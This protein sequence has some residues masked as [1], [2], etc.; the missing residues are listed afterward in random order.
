MV[1]YWFSAPSKFRFT[2][3][4]LPAFVFSAAS[5]ITAGVFA[6]EDPDEADEEAEII[7]EVLVT[8]SRIKRRDFTSISPIATFS[9]EDI[10]FSGITNLEDLAN[11]MPQLVA[12]FG[13][14]SNNPGNGAAQ[15][16]L[17]GLGP[18]RTLVMLNGHRAAPHDVFGAVD[19]NS[20]P[21]ALVQRVELVTG[22]ASTVY[23]SDAVSGVVN[24]ILKTDFTGVELSTQFDIYGAGDGEVI[25]AS[26]SFGSDFSDGRGHIMGFVNYQERSAV[27]ADA[28][29]FTAVTLQENLN[30]P[31][32]ELVESGSTA[33]PGG[34][35]W[36]PPTDLPGIGPTNNIIFNSDGSAR[37]FIDPDDLFNFAPDNYLQT[38]FERKMVGAFGNFQLLDDLNAFAEFSYAE[39]QSDQQLAPSP[40]FEFIAFNVDHPSLTPEQQSLAV[41]NWDADG[42]GIAD[43]F[44]SRRLEEIGPRQLFTNS[45]SWRAL[46]GLKGTFGFDW[47]WE[48]AFSYSE[49]TKDEEQVNGVSR[50]RLLQA[51]L[52]DPASGQC[53]D[54][55]NGCVPVS[56]FGDGSITMEAAEFLRSVDIFNNSTVEEQI[57]SFNTTGDVIDLPA[58]ALAMAVGVEWRDL[59][60]TFVSDPALI[61]GNVLG[62]NSESGVD[63]SFDVKEVYAEVLVPIL[64]GKT[65]AHYLGL[66][67]GVRYSD[68][69]LSGGAW[70]W[71]FGIDWTP[72]K[73]LRFRAMSQRAVRAPNINELFRAPIERIA[74]SSA[75]FDGC[76]ASLDPVGN[77][78]TDLCIAQGIA[79]DQL[80]VF[81]ALSPFPTTLFFGGG[82]TK[83]DP[84]K[85][86]TFTVGVVIQPGGIEGLSLAIDYYNI[87]INNSIGSIDDGLALLECFD[88]KDA[89]SAFCESIVRGPSGDIIEFTVPQFNLALSKASGIDLILDY[90][91]GLPASLAIGDQEASWAL[92]IFAN[93][94]IE[95]GDQASPSSD[96]ID[97]VGF[98]GFICD[99]ATIVPE[100]R[101]NT[102]LT[103]F[104]G[105]LSASLSWDWIGKLHNHIFLLNELLGTDFATSIPTASPQNY[106]DL[107]LHY[108][109]NDSWEFHGGIS[110]LFENTPPLLG[111]GATQ[112]NTAPQLFDIF[113]RR[114]FIGVKFRL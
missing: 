42:D 113:G 74:T 19:V 73:S 52:A 40:F 103:Y 101:V 28:R 35:I 50:N 66:E 72:V 56:L 65:F 46:A 37:P 107:S 80:G 24:F 22:G 60:S 81:E 69:S 48:A 99:S 71:K 98:F 47:D 23:G 3:K 58:G 17:R 32:G 51:L 25:D 85:A 12:S 78:L 96:F 97:C 2:G 6:Q 108:V 7:E 45:K 33:I 70:N 59:S 79:A 27:L 76:S 82:N 91:H 18:G 4:L 106:I 1:P 13:R 104:S 110:N 102:R 92:R 34:R 86:D 114:Y 26:L 64:A 90:G 111:W 38:P 94:T 15:L 39:T 53:F 61:G 29:E 31:E 89:N 21:S 63:G 105:P 112:S 20:I 93:H 95:K 75:L 9:A 30:S 109:L 55:S 88:S 43:V 44:L 84:E 8:G 67:A 49:T 62:F 54:P 36:F 87:E 100:N 83:L 77:G 57:F 10:T 41:N 14:T 68:Y 5:F 16:D 11:D